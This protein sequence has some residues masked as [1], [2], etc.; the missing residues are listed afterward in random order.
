MNCLALFIV[1][2]LG[3]AVLGALATYQVWLEVEKRKRKML[4]APTAVIHR[5][6]DCDCYPGCWAE[7]SAAWPSVPTDAGGVVVASIRRMLP[8]GCYVVMGNRVRIEPAWYHAIKQGLAPDSQAGG[9]VPQP[10]ES[11]GQK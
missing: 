11:P 7:H 3:G 2:V 9:V 8:R 4:E 10:P 6:L 5:P 1:G